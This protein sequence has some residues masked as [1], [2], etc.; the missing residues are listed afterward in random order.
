MPKVLIAD[1]VNEECAK[2]LKDN[3]IEVEQRT[4]LTEDE[5]AAIVPPYNGI[6]VRSGI[7]VTK[8]VIDAGKGLKIIGRAGVGVDNIDVKAATEKNVAVVNVP[9]GNVTAA[10][11]HTVAL[12]LALAKNVVK[13][14]NIMRQGK[15]DRKFL[16][17]E[18]AG[19]TLGIIGF[20]KVGSKVARMAM[21]FGMRIQVFTLAAWQSIE[22]TGYRRVS[23]EELI[24]TSDFITVHTVLN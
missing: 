7:K 17:V 23:L 9:H 24:S 18:L 3:K 15:W 2:I 6:I 8:K 16:G 1:Q 12:M 20:G 5:F 11:E 4:K 14:D 21:V 10:A 22:L 13:G 19:K